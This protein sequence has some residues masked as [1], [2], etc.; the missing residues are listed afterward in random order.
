MV[1]YEE[2]REIIKTMWNGDYT[3]KEIGMKLG[4]TRNAVMGVV[5]RMIGKGE[6]LHKTKERQQIAYYRVMNERKVKEP[7]KPKIRKPVK[8][9]APLVI[10]VEESED[11]LQLTNFMSLKVDSCRYSISGK[12]A[13]EYIF[14]NEPATQRSYCDHHYSLCYVKKETRPKQLKTFRENPRKGYVFLNY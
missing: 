8:M 12:K 10:K 5:H 3:G 14:C 9:P 11:P 13:S 1:S 4:M 2:R 6:L 7:V